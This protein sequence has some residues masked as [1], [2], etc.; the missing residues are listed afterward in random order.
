MATQ[1]KRENGQEGL[2][3]LRTS[4]LIEPLLDP[5]TH[6]P[7]SMQIIR[8]LHQGPAPPWR[9]SPSLKASLCPAW[10]LNHGHRH[11]CH[12]RIHHMAVQEDMGR[13]HPPGEL[14]PARNLLD[15]GLFCQAIYGPKHSLG[16]LV[17]EAPAGEEPLQTRPD[18]TACKVP[19][20]T[21]AP[22]AAR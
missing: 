7:E 18:W 12:E 19:C 9:R 22:A 11:A 21:R 2:R 8:L 13:N 14:M 4:L 1:A 15:P 6:R 10:L 16:A 3:V 5:Y 20:L 17:S